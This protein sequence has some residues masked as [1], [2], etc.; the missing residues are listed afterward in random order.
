MNDSP[1][2]TIR[3]LK[4]LVKT[5]PTPIRLRQSNEDD[6]HL[7]RVESVST[8]GDFVEIYYPRGYSESCTRIENPKDWIIFPHKDHYVLTYRPR[9]EWALKDILDQFFYGIE[10][11]RGR[12]ILKIGDEKVTFLYAREGDNGYIYLYVE[13][14]HIP[15]NIKMFILPG[16]TRFFNTPDGNW[17]CKYKETVYTGHHD[18]PANL[19]GNVLEHLYISGVKHEFNGLISNS[20]FSIISAVDEDG[21]VCYYYTTEGSR[22]RIRE[23]GITEYLID[24]VRKMN[25]D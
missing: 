22:L 8:G 24:H 6:R 21:E 23:H 16:T 11:Q 7:K 4:D 3:Q 25:L 14:D 15:T 13:D 12:A 10:S 9:V 5:S 1:Y 18:V 2:L 17:V 19:R 20:R